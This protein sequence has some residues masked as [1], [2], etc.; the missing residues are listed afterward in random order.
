MKF[1]KTAILFILIT[2]FHFGLKSQSDTQSL[3]PSFDVEEKQGQWISAVYSVV[4][5]EEMSFVGLSAYESLIDTEG[6]YKY[7]TSHEGVWSSWVDFSQTIENAL[8]DRRIFEAPPITK[9]FEGMMIT[10]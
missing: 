4:F 1:T 5:K 3:N 10:F 8:L 7:R 9:S 6:Y 2:S